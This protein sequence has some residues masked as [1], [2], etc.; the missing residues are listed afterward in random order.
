MTVGRHPREYS[1]CAGCGVE[2]ADW[3]QHRTLPQVGQT[4]V[5]SACGH[6]AYVYDA[7]DV[8]ET[9]RQF[10]PVT[11]SMARNLLFYDAADAWPGSVFDARLQE[12]PEHIAIDFW[13]VEREDWSQSDWAAA[14]AVTQ[15]A[16]SKNVA[17]A[18]ARLSG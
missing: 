5:C 15:Q 11:T 12:A 4:Y 16:V 2:D 14:I 10:R 9:R 17:A 8:S 7:G 3:E 6:E 18:R 13:M 1:P